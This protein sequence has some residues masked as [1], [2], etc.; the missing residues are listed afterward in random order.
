MEISEALTALA[1]LA[2]ATRLAAFRLLVCAGSDGMAAGEIAQKLDIPATTLSFH[3]KEL[4]RAGLID[5]RREGRSIRY[6]LRVE[7][8]QEF[9]KF[10]SEDCCQGHPEL[11]V[12]QTSS[13][14][15][16]RPAKARASARI[17]EEGRGFGR[18]VG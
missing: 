4:T 13:S 10:L 6:A 2:Q 1:A 17:K 14:G 7:G 3:L 9:L 18:K 8:M 11:C 15:K 12:P 5:F 16:K